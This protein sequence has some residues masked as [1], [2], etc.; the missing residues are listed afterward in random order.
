M[1]LQAVVCTFLLCLVCVLLKTKT[2]AVMCRL[3]PTFMCGLFLDVTVHHQ[4]QY[5]FQTY[6]Y[7]RQ[8]SRMT[9]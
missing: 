2:P 4:S 9:L 6:V 7:P 8:E 1:R 3:I 5:T